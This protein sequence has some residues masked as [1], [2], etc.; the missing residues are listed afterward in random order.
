[1][2]SSLYLVKVTKMKM[3]TKK[4]VA[5]LLTGGVIYALSKSQDS[6]PKTA[7]HPAFI[8]PQGGIM[9]DQTEDELVMAILKYRG[10]NKELRKKD[11]SKMP[12][13]DYRLL[14]A[15]FDAAIA[16]YPD[17]SGKKRP[18]QNLEKIRRDLVKY[19]KDIVAIN[20][21]AGVY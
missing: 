17:P 20:G 19:R 11:G 4:I 2:Q 13:E 15:D 1:V 21:F 14:L 16:Y 9:D 18:Q 12:E 3:G 8:Y 5:W 10:Y 7:V 6:T